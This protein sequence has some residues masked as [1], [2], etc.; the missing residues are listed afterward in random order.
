VVRPADV[1]RAK[2]SVQA[3]FARQGVGG[4]ADPERS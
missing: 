1:G 2:K 4:D 3:S